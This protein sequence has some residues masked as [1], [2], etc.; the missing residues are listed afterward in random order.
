MKIIDRTR[1][2]KCTQGSMQTI[3]ETAIPEFL[4]QPRQLYKSGWRQPHNAG[5]Q[6]KGI[7]TGK[8]PEGPP[9][10]SRI[11]YVCRET[12]RNL[13]GPVNS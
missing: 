11:W 13:G 1:H 6:N 9:G 8:I 2:M 10:S 4:M 5:S 7:V 12:H 3:R